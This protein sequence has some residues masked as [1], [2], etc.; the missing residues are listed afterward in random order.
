MAGF[1][2]RAFLQAAAG[3][4][5]AAARSETGRQSRPNVLLLMSDQHRW[6]AFGFTGNSVIR[7]PNFDKLAAGGT[8]FTECWAQHPVCM[9]SRASIFT[10]R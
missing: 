3:G 9:P 1:T 7:T 6:D 4:T 5:A 2:R 10:G 8:R